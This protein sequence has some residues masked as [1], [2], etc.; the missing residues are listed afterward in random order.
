MV[1]HGTRFPQFEGTYFF[2]DYQTGDLWALR[3][4]GNVVTEVRTLPLNEPGIA[5]FGTDPRNGDLLV[6]DFNSGVVRR[7]TYI[8]P[9]AGPVLPGTLAETGVF[10]NPANRSVPPG[11]ISYQVNVPSWA[12]NGVLQ[13]WF[14]V[15]DTN[16]TVAWKA[17]GNWSFPTGTVW[18]QHIDLRT[19]AI[20]PRIPVET[21]LLV[22]T[23]DGVY[24]A[25]YRWGGQT[26]AT[27]VGE[28]GDSELFTI[29]DSSGNLVRNLNWIYPS[30]TDCI[31]CH[32]STGGF[33]LGFNTAQLNLNRS[34]PSSEFPGA[35]GTSANQ[36][37]SLA[38]VGYFG[39][40]VPDPATLP[41][42]A[43]WNN[44]SATLE[45]RVRSYLAANCVQCHQAD[46]LQSG[47]WD[48]R[49]HISL[50]QSSIIWGWLNQN[51]GNSNAHVITPHSLTNSMIFQRLGAFV[52][53]RM[54]PV[55][56]SLVDTNNLNLMAQWIATL[57]DLQ[58]PYLRM[59]SGPH[60]GEVSLRW[61]ADPDF[62]D[63]FA[64]TNPALPISWSR[65]TTSIV[66]SNGQR[67]VTVPVN[68]EPR[69]FYQL[70]SR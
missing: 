28:A 25:T 5:A 59:T 52:G 55:G 38:A 54:P 47:N 56:S 68:S 26:N 39:N 48:A 70:E 1:Y 41:A 36:I 4:D 15:P 32:N 40:P 67:I 21:R 20:L 64:T 30:R 66:V 53:T 61:P 2:A 46:V 63:L 69:K 57:S 58:P 43:L 11:V 3:Y 17:D 35:T 42:F 10:A 8:E 9:P 45:W 18:I 62:F 24:G 22:R 6:V 12:D 29:T 50:P 51:F 65:E 16:L 49:Y 60:E 27:L 23:T 34:Y 31:R 33:A 37:S 13:R 7:L 44:P 19:N 14:T